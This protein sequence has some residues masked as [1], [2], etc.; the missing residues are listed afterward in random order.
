MQISDKI[1]DYIILET[2]GSGTDSVV[3]RAKHRT[4]GYYVAVKLIKSE[5]V[6]DDEFRQMIEDEFTIHKT[7]SQSDFIIKIY[8]SFVS[9][10]MGYAILDL[11]EESLYVYLERRKKLDVSESL[12]IFRQ[13]CKAVEYMHERNYKH[14]DIK[15]GNI[16]G[17]GG[18]WKLADFGFSTPQNYSRRVVG[19][20]IYMPVE[21]YRAIRDYRNKV[22]YEKSEEYKCKP[23]DIWSLGIILYNILLG[24][25]PSYVYEK[26]MEVKIKGITEFSF[27]NKLIR[28]IAYKPVIEL[29]NYVLDKNPETRPDI[30]NVLK[31][32][33][34]NEYEWYSTLL[35]FED[36]GVAN[37]VKWMRGKS[38]TESSANVQILGP[39]NNGI[40]VAG[41]VSKGKVNELQAFLTRANS[42]PYID[43]L[44][45]K[46][47]SDEFVFGE[48]IHIK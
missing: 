29:I 44:I 43:E 37:S 11:C 21:I 22:P 3:K 13:M 46:K 8:G 42:V 5:I 39:T 35:E 36:I 18:V 20:Q 14:L 17:C 41:L 28:R 40:F 48:Y 1:E 30:S 38:D 34:L 31:H 32:P 12:F 27:E 6:E 23:V 45:K 7:L 19:T 10:N 16:M 33:A 15:P 25:Y 24:E 9:P 4:D 26:D 47:N 2:V